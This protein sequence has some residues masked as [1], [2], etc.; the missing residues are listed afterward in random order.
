[1][2]RQEPA[3]ASSGHGGQAAVDDELTRLRREVAPLREA[4]CL[5]HHSDRGSQD[6]SA[7]SCARLASAGA[8][9]SMSRRGTCWDNALMESFS[10]RMKEMEATCFE[11]HD[12]ARQAL[13][14]PIELH[15]HRP[16]RHSGL[17]D[18]SPYEFEIKK[19]LHPLSDLARDPPRELR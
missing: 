13:F 6:T 11:T 19:P 4:R 10:G 9:S 17:D 8:R 18:V 1:M 14:K 16:R 7:A 12:E 5:L 15:D 2:L 3:H